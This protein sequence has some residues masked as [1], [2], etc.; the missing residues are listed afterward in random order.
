M[1]NGRFLTGESPEHAQV[2]EKQSG[3]KIQHDK[4]GWLYTEKSGVE[5]LDSNA[6]LS[7]V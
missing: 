3:I 5:V 1:R 7:T 4:Q 2:V 6:T